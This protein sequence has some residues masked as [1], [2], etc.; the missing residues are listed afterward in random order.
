MS[1]LLPSFPPLP[2]P[3]FR[4]SSSTSFA[5]IAKSVA[6]QRRGRGQQG[7][8]GRGRGHC[9]SCKRLHARCAECP[10]DCAVMLLMSSPQV[11]KQ[12]QCFKWPGAATPSIHGHTDPRRLAA[13][14]SHLR[15]SPRRMP[16]RP[17]PQ[18]GSSGSSLT[19]ER[20]SCDQEAKGPELL[21][22]LA[23]PA[24]RQ[25]SGRICLLWPLPADPGAEG[26]LT[27]WAEAGLPP[28]GVVPC[29]QLHGALA[30]AGTHFESIGNDLSSISRR[31]RSGLLS[32]CL[33]E[34]RKGDP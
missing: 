13:V 32:V 29:V 33:P 16:P 17:P 22:L 15:P 21:A 25:V 3:H 4:Q 27:W 11:Q 6:V 5:N 20:G 2:Q 30:A 26:A 1:C 19:Q 10:R 18:E 9:Q 7:A 14:L 23:S 8:A 31:C 24:P 28:H 12:A 34:K